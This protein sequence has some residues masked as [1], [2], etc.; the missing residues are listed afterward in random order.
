MDEAGDVAGA[1]R[2]TGER[3][4][5]SDALFPHE[6]AFY[7]ALF[8]LIGVA[9]S[10]F[11]AGGRM[12]FLL[13]GGVFVFLMAYA[14]ATNP[15][16]YSKIAFFSLAIGVGALYY[17]LYNAYTAPDLIFSNGGALA[18]IVTSEPKRFDSSQEFTASL[19]SPSRGSVRVVAS[20][21]PTREYG[22]EIEIIGEDIEIAESGEVTA[23]FPDIRLIGKGRGSATKGALLAVR[24]RSIEAIRN[25]LPPSSAA[26]LSG[27]LFGD[28]TGFTKEFRAAMRETGTTHLVALSGYNLMIIASAVSFFFAWFVSRRKGFWITLALVGAFVAM[29]GGEASVVRAAIMSAIFLIGEMLGRAHSLTNALALAAGLM[30]LANPRLP[31]HDL[32][33]ELSFLAFAGIAFLEPWLRKL[34]RISD[35]SG[36]LNTKRIAIT[37]LS[38]QAATAPLL[39]ARTGSASWYAVIPNTLIALATPAIMLLGFITIGVGFVSSPAASVVGWAAHYLVSYEIGVITF[40][41]R[42]L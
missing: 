31:A 37:A 16:R 17:H 9:L 2:H 32:G 14:R 35:E 10:G 6:G 39:L 5:D 41:A 8:F 11:G 25:T 20:P 27:M 38:A 18:A 7:L 34:F 12:I 4:A 21:Y 40:F 23:L 30:A 29:T 1:I 22:D 33:F 15:P 28:A 3:D 36:F 13:A 42:A 24:R 26:M 19:V